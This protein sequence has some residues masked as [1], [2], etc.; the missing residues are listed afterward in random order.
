MVKEEGNVRGAHETGNAGT[1]TY[2]IP[3]LHPDLHLLSSGCPRRETSKFP[4]LQI[5][6]ISE[7]HTHTANTLPTS[8]GSPGPPTLDLWPPH[9]T[10][11]SPHVAPQWCLWAPDLWCPAPKGPGATQDNRIHFSVTLRSSHKTGVWALYLFLTADSLRDNNPR[12]W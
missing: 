2:E 8:A 10:E 5:N 4:C 1:E 3:T 6:L 7:L 12:R 11:R 9:T